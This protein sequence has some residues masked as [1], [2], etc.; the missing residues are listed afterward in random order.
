[1]GVN[2]FENVQVQSLERPD[3]GIWVR[4][5][6]GGEGGT[7]CMLRVCW[8]DANIRRNEAEKM[9]SDLGK[10]VTW[11]TEGGGEERAVD[12]FAEY[13]SLGECER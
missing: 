2:S 9:V 3:V 4:A 1:V 11:M 10:A 13:S 5:G 6:M 12:G 7:T 8:D